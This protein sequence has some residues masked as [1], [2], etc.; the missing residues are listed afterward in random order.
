MKEFLATSMLQ[1]FGFSKFATGISSSYEAENL[2][3]EASLRCLT[4]VAFGLLRVL[5]LNRYLR[6]TSP[7]H[8]K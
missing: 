4:I 5:S 7:R 6:E 2:L 3:N 8:Y 1:P